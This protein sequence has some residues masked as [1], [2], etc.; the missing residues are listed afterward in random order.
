[1]TDLQ[2]ISWVASHRDAAHFEKDLELYREIFPKSAIIE[3][4]DSILPHQKKEY[5]ERIL[6]ELVRAIDPG[7]IL[8]NRKPSKKAHE[9][10]KTMEEFKELLNS[11]DLET[12]DQKSLKWLSNGLEL[13]PENFKKS[14]LVPFLQEY[15]AHLI[16][17]S[18]NGINPKTVIIDE[19]IDIATLEKMRD[20]LSDKSTGSRDD[21]EHMEAISRLETMKAVTDNEP[22]KTPEK[23]N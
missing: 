23:K 20:G 17:K 14:T 7:D 1:M 11:S 10:A 6:L 5:D 18:T 19:M 22:I 15:K 9:G 16:A 8:S 4:L 21:L 13:S 12:M 3:S 2:N